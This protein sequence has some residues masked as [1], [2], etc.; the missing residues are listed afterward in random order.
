MWLWLDRGIASSDSIQLDYLAA[1][2]DG[3][4]GLSFI[5]EGNEEVTSVVSLGEKVPNAGAVNGTATL[6]SG[7]EKSEVS[8]SGGKFTITV[9]PKKAVSVIL[10][11]PELKAPEYAKFSYTLNGNYPIQQTVL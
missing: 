8:V 3:V 11:I 9:Q 2:K 4:L 10:N 6:Y 1:R 5:N 7:G